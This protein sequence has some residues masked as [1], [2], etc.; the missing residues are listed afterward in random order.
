[1]SDE[2]ASATPVLALRGVQ[3]G[4]EGVPVVQGVDLSVRAGEVVAVLGANG[5]GKTTLVRG[6][7][8]LAEVQAGEVELFGRPATRLA[9]RHRIGYV[10][11]RQNVAGAIPSTVREVVASGRLS[12]RRLFSRWT[13]ADQGAVDEALRTVALLDRAS[14]EVASLSGGQQRRVLIARALAGEP[15][16][17]VMDEPTAGVDASSQ[18]ALAVTVRRLAD[19]KVTLLIV[20]HEVGPL[21]DVVSRAVVMSR[22]RMVYDGPL[23]G[24]PAGAQAVLDDD[25]HHCH[26]DAAGTGPSWVPAPANAFDPQRR[27]PR[28]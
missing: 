23:T 16:V 15:D 21:S 24:A 17:L 22:G 14:E 1:M 3:V 12:R 19:R 6:L 27:E 10:P 18:E 9:E 11:Q 26:D 8:G 20:T 7:L 13:P 25:G 4:Y 2:N 28:A 5:S